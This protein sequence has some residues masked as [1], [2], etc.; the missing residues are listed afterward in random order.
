M[1][2]RK[3]VTV[4]RLDHIIGRAQFKSHGFHCQPTVTIIT[5]ISAN[6]RIRFQTDSE[7][8]NHHRSGIMTSSVYNEWLHLF[9][10]TQTFFRQLAAGDPRETLVLVRKSGTSG[11]ADR[12]VIIDHQDWY[13][14]SISSPRG[15]AGGSLV[16]SVC[17]PSAISCRDFGWKIYGK[18]GNPG[19]ASLS[20]EIRPL[21]QS[22]VPVTDGRVPQACPSVLPGYGDIRLGKL[23]K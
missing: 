11:P 5:G 6:F 14:G 4:N 21:H 17:V 16:F 20:T 2:T 3:T 23:L 19:P 7:R 13:P 8:P 9:G 12:G 10:Q 15:M 1:R 18:D 22:D